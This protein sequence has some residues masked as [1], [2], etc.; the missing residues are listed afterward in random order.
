MFQINAHD[1]D[2]HVDDDADDDETPKLISIIITF[3][4]E[5]A[6]LEL[7]PSPHA[8]NSCS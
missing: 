3:R 5:T 7:L 1:V 4:L 6:V 2:V 8:P